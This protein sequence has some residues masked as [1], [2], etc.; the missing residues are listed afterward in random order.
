[1]SEKHPKERRQL[2]R[3]PAAE[4]NVSWRPRKGLFQRYRPA[5]GLDFT[6]NGLS[7][8]VNPEDTLAPGDTVEMALELIMEAGTL[9]VDRVVAVV[10]N[11]RDQPGS[12]PLY[13][14]GFDFEANRLMKSEQMVAQLGRIE[15]ILERSEKLKLKIQPLS[16]IETLQESL[17]NS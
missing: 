7:L 12:S 2:R 6:R 10:H 1:M 14:V 3:L 4:L 11:V 16:D 13:G 15:G 8:R 5:E 17:D 9:N